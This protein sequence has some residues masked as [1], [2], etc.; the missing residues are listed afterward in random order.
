VCEAAAIIEN[1]EVLKWAREHNCP[2]DSETCRA[3]AWVGNKVVLRW[4]REHGC[5]E[6]WDDGGASEEEDESEV[7]HTSEEED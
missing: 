3:A 4:A 5:P 2:W 1:L 6:D 7:E